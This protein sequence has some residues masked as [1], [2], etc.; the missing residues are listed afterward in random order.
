MSEEKTKTIDMSMNLRLLIVLITAQMKSGVTAMKR[1]RAGT[2][3]M[4]F[5]TNFGIIAKR[6]A[7]LTANVLLLENPRAIRNAKRIPDAAIICDAT[8]VVSSIDA[9]AVIERSATRTKDAEGYDSGYRP[10]GLKG[11]TIQ[12]MY[13]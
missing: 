7:T 10:K 9:D 4:V 8:S 6:S 12:A 1:P 5:V 13:P 11:W 3:H 2:S